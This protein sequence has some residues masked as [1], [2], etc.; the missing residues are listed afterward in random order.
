MTRTVRPRLTLSR[1]Q[2]QALV[3]T[4]DALLSIGGA[5][6]LTPGDRILAAGLAFVLAALASAII[7]TDLPVAI[8]NITQ[9]RVETLDERERPIRNRA[10]FAHWS[11]AMLAHGLPT[12]V[13]AWTQPGVQPKMGAA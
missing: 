5:A 9:V 13:A 3:V 7:H 10:W 6:R 4:Q 11:L 8:D 2:R 12:A 1:F